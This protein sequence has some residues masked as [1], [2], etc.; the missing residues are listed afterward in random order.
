MTA[1]VIPTQPPVIPTGAEESLVAGHDPQ[2][3]PPSHPSHSEE[4]RLVL[5]HEGIP[6]STT[7]RLSD[8]TS[9]AESTPPPTTD[10]LGVHINAI[11]MPIAIETIERW[12]DTG[13]REYVAVCAVHSIMEADRDPAFRDILNKAGLRVPD[14]MPLV[15]LSQRAGHQQTGR[16]R[17]ADLVDALCARSAQTGHHH[18]FYGGAPG[19]AQEM[20]RRLQVR[21]PGLQVAGA[22][23]PAALAVGEEEPPSVIETINAAQP[24]ILW[25]GLGCPKQE[26]WMALHRDSLDV[27]VVIGVGAAFDFHSGAVNQAPLWMQNTG[28]EWVHRL[29]SEPE[30]LASRYFAC[31]TRFALSLRRL[32]K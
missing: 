30:R 20:A 8:E 27:P 28:L 5:R 31:N 32:I 24:D 2:D 15:W 23:T 13:Q 11:D 29:F 3:L 12:V 10:L 14:G 21:H 22:S 18:Y 19:I 7:D 6:R 17:G 9:P 4:G 1:T 16:V 26:W 25:I